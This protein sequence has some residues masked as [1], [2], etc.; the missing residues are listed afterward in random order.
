MRKAE[1]YAIIAT[2]VVLI[3]LLIISYDSDIPVYP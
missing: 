3:A 2:V 1:I